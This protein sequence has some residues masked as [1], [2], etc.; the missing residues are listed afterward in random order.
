MFYYKTESSFF[1]VYER[2]HQQVTKTTAILLFSRTAASEA[3][4]KPLVFHKTKAEKVAD[5]LIKKTKSIAKA[6]NLPVFFISEKKQRG[7]TFGE[8]LGNAFSDIFEKGYDNVIS[9]GN[10]CLDI[11]PTNLI[12]AAEILNEKQ[13]VLG[14]TLDGGVYLIGLNRTTFKAL[15]F[16][17]I[18]WQTSKVFTELVSFSKKQGFS[19]IFLDKKAD[20]DTAFDFKKAIKTFAILLQKSIFALLNDTCPIHFPLFQT[21]PNPVF[22][23]TQSLRAPPVF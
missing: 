2:K 21:I 11:S 9:I 20:F 8:K 1:I 18:S 22:L 17:T 5:I 6:T 3:A 10:D 12:N 14:E 7:N 23:S 4:A 15:D 16:S 13:V 19:S